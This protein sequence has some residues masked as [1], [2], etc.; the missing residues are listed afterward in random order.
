MNRKIILGSVLTLS[1]LW[2]AGQ[3]VFAQG[4]LPAA[5]AAAV[6]PGSVMSGDMVGMMSMMS[7]SSMQ[8]MMNG[9]GAEQMMQA[10]NS[11]EGQKLM[12]ECGN[13]MNQG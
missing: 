2:G 9:Q 6:Q 12:G 8:N 11:S 7:N 3:A 5:P 10:M 4:N 13:F 1:V